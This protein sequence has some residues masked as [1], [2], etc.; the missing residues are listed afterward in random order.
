MI[1]ILKYLKPY[2]LLILLTIVL[3]FVQAF[4]DLA[5]PSY[6][7]DIV[8]IGIQ[9]GGIE[10]AVPVAI[11]QSSMDKVT[12][13]M[14]PEGKTRVLSDY[15]LVD[16]NSPDYATYVE[17][18]PTLAQEPVYVLN[19][20]DDEEIA[21]LNPVMGEAILKVT[22]LASMGFDLSKVPPGMDLSSLISQLPQEQQAMIVAANQKLEGMSESVIVQAAAGPILA[23]YTALGMDTMKLSTSYIIQIGLIMLLITLIS[24]TCMIIVGYL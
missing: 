13:F 18:Y 14:S 12:I 1:R 10:N 16:Q 19:D 22:G 6:M 9:Q 21:W 23:E 15:T 17:L 11:R 4:A 24:G 8:N 7:A 5:L 2:R 3:L 20:I